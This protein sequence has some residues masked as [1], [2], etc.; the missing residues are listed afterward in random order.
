LFFFDFGL[1]ISEERFGE[2][3]G[4]R[5]QE[6]RVDRDGASPCGEVTGRMSGLWLG[7]ALMLRAAPRRPHG[8]VAKGSN[9]LCCDEPRENTSSVARYDAVEPLPF[10]M[11]AVQ[12]SAERF[13][14]REGNELGGDI[15]PE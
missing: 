15:E 8:L 14:G 4:E 11:S 7:L 13:D 5:L 2:D 9:L 3:V 1:E 6:L 10:G 12:I